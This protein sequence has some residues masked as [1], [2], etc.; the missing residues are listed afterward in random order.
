MEISSIQY[1]YIG[2][3]AILVGFTK[4]SVG[5]V[6]ILAVLLM[7]LAIP[8]KAS[9][10]VLLPMLIAADIMAVIYYRRSCKW[11]I[12][13]SLMPA[14]VVG[15]AL[16][17]A[18]LWLVPDANFEKII[19]WVILGMLALDLGLGE[20][21]KRHAQGPVLTRFVGVIA[22][23]T[24][25]IANAA[26]PVFGI[27]LLQMGLNKHQFVGTRSWYFLI[28]NLAK[29]PFAIGLG[30]VT[31]TTLTLNLAYLPVIL[32]GAIL[33]YRFLRFLNVRVFGVLIRL[34]ALV[35]A[36]RLILW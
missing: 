10:G 23:A 36:A 9:P 4:T 21:L 25:M 2:L 22:G 24:S 6:G 32:L 1:L 29:M 27:Y 3:A 16:G 13:L 34:A 8:G 11:A 14:A 35:A 5:G 31:P 15:V 12:L 19:G 20:A 28:M 18:F 33:G 30:L 17:A 26:G 7:A